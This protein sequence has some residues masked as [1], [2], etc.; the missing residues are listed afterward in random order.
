MLAIGVLPVKAEPVHA[1]PSRAI[2]QLGTNGGGFMNANSAHPFENPN[3]WT[4]II[5]AKATRIQGASEGERLMLPSKSNFRGRRALCA[6][7][8]LF[9]I[10]A[11][12]PDPRRRPSFQ[13]I[14]GCLASFCQNAE[15]APLIH[16]YDVNTW[17]DYKR[18]VRSRRAARGG[19]AHPGSVAAVQRERS[20]DTTAIYLKFTSFFVRAG[21]LTNLRACGGGRVLAALF[22]L[23]GFSSGASIRALYV[24][25]RSVPRAHLNRAE[26][27][28]ALLVRQIAQFQF[29]RAGHTN[30]ELLNTL[31]DADL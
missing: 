15:H 13:G 22:W 30:A 27:V 23:F 3:A 8:G 6:V 9:R 4:N 1:D 26:H 14:S 20:Y 11:D 24:S 18:R 10:S 21:Q 17:R 31:Q 28:P 2:K 25:G 7:L 29:K 12:P 16:V 19:N 5:R